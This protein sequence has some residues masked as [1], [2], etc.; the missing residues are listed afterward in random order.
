M[1]SRDDSAHLLFFLRIHSNLAGNCQTIDAKYGMMRLEAFFYALDLVNLD[2]KSVKNFDV[3]ALIFDTCENANQ[4]VI[5]SVGSTDSMVGIIGP[6][7]SSPV[8]IAS[9]VYSSFATKTA[10]VTYGGTSD[11][12]QDD[13]EYNNLFHT[14]PGNSDM[15]DALTD[16][17]LHYNWTFVAVLYAAKDIDSGFSE[18]KNVASKKGICIKYSSPVRNN[19][20]EFSFSE[21]LAPLKKQKKVEVIF[22]LLTDVMAAGLFRYISKHSKEFSNLNF[23]GGQ[24]LGTKEGILSNDKFM[25]LGV[26]TLE[27]ESPHDPTFD[28]Y[29]LS[30]TPKNNKRN[31]YFKPFWEKLFNCSVSEEFRNET[32]SITKPLKRCN[33]DETMSEGRG[34]YKDAPVQPIINAVMSFG[35]ALKLAANETPLHC[36]S[37]ECFEGSGQYKNPVLDYLKQIRFNTSL[38]QQ[39][40]FNAK[41]RLRLNYTV[42]NTQ[43]L[44]GNVKF[45]KVG[46]WKNNPQRNMKQRLFLNDS[47][48]QWRLKKVPVSRCGFDCSSGEIRVYDAAFLCCWTCS[49]C[50]ENNVVVN[51]TCQP[52]QLWT[53]SDK[54][55]RKC[56]PMKLQSIEIGTAFPILIIFFSA[57]LFSFLLVSLFFF[58][59]YFNSRTVKASSRELSLVSQLGLAVLVLSPIS[60]LSEPSLFI[61]NLQQ[62]LFGIGLTL[63][64]VPLFL[65]AMVIY[66]VVRKARRSVSIPKLSDKRS[67]SLICLGLVTIQVLLSTLWLAGNPMSEENYKSLDNRHIIKHCTFNFLSLV[68]SFLYPCILSTLATVLVMQTKSQKLPASVYEGKQTVFASVFTCFVLFLYLASSSVYAK[69]K[70][71]F[72]Q[73]YSF[74]VLCLLIVAAYVSCLFVPRLTTLTCFRRTELQPSSEL[75]NVNPW[76]QKYSTTTEALS[77]SISKRDSETESALQKTVHRN[78][79]MLSIVVKSKDPSAHC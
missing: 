63:C 3:G 28:N 19:Y 8:H 21:V 64:S 20:K 44:N 24:H 34:F 57:C 32:L 71:S 2:I 65:K 75:G 40:Q 53:F 60:F 9:V 58:I 50:P 62:C 70:T 45:H 26:I 37:G 25:E 30:L 11:L 42:Y 69:D 29:Y 18:F 55:K 49:V 54:D 17:A 4:Q 72:L 16:I 52:C 36:L 51:N 35:A 46:S 47:K 38:G 43:L 73:E 6:E 39:L 23:L 77:D 27:V 1:H 56:L 79:N 15:V 48:I 59:K 68:V 78:T 41:N 12:L 13:Q 5:C 61:C 10:V 22:L 31:T 7:G 67:Q 76:K 74:S 66:R 14:V 33:G